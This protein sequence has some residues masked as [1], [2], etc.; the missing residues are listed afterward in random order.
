MMTENT[1]YHDLIQ[2]AIERE[3]DVLGLADAVE[4]AN[5]VEGLSVDDEGTVVSVSGEG[6]AVLGDLVDAYVEASGDVAAFLIA[7]RVENVSDSDLDL[8]E[9]LDKHM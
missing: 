8:P 1:G 5:Q 9:N 4:R 6:K 3:S 7:R 2:A